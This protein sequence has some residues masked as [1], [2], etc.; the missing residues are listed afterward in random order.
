MERVILTTELRTEQDIVLARQRARQIAGLLGFESQDQTRIATAV[1]E[2]TRNAFEYAG[3]GRVEFVLAPS[4]SPRPSASADPGYRG[5]SRGK[6]D[7]FWVR[8]QDRGQGIRDL[9][10]I[11]DGQYRSSTGMG[12]GIIG[13]KRLMDEFQIESSPE[14]GTAVRM[15]KAL[16]PTAPVVTPQTVGKIGAELARTAPHDPTA[17]ILQ[18]NQELMRS[19][20][21]LRARQGEIER[22]NRELEDTNRGVVALYTELDEKAGYLQR[23]AELKS[24]FLSNMSHEFRTP[25]NAILSLSQILLDRTDGELVGEQEKQVN[26]IRKAATDLSELVNDLL[27][28]ARV[29]AGKVLIRPTEFSVDDL[30]GALRGMLR[31]LLAHN[32]SVSLLF[33]AEPGLPNLKSDEGKVSQ[34]LRNLISNALKFTEFGEVSITARKGPEGTIVF[35]VSDTGIGIA[36][37]DQ[38]R[39]FEEFTQVEGPIQRRVK[40]TGLGLPLSRKLARLLGGSITVES[41]PGVGSTFSFT[42]PA[43]YV[44]PNEVTYVPEVTRQIDPRRKPVLV[45]ED[46]RETLF[47]YEKF[48]KGT[49]FQP[50]PARTLREAR[51]ALSQFRPATVVLDVLLEDESTWNFLSELKEGERTRDLPVIVATVIDNQAKAR[52]LG[53]SAFGVKPLQRDWLLRQLRQLSSVEPPEKLLIVDDDEISRYLLRGLLSTMRYTVLEADG[54]EL[55]LSMARDQSPRAIF[56]DLVMPTMDGFETLE[57]LRSDPVT[58]DIPVI[59]NTSSRLD[60]ASTARLAEKT[61]AILSKDRSNREDALAAVRR[62]LTAAGVL[63]DAAGKGAGHA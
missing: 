50:I 47:I 34:V 8:V 16:P 33:E 23:A 9:A 5:V 55:G 10:T 63:E 58:R 14:G 37:E 45:V 57:R 52:T 4:T 22:L 51:E 7:L 20:E 21:A 25:L 60:E 12:L 56:L 15:A 11:L 44:G 24:S 54:G 39:I 41:A 49:E 27:D 61:S 46:N 1:S 35:A 19:L 17:E 38:E 28:L 6:R 36:P 31:P 53:A 3:G 29:E 43:A 62:A 30:F 13:A 18:Q 26:F 48:L 32:S 2:I 40:G 59:I 42:L